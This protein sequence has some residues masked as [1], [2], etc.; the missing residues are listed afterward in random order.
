VTNLPQNTDP[1]KQRELPTEPSTSEFAEIAKRLADGYQ[2]GPLLNCACCHR[3]NADQ[4]CIDRGICAICWETIEIHIK[5][6]REV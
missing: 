2:F 5:L 1:N 3:A 4:D 6:D